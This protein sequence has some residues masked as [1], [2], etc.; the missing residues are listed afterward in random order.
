[1]R[2][3]HSLKKCAPSDVGCGG[4][5][6]HINELPLS[7]AALLSQNGTTVQFLHATRNTQSIAAHEVKQEERVIGKYRYEKKNIKDKKE[8]YKRYLE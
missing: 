1:M 3:T 6:P 7:P 8:P 4:G 2:M 5:K